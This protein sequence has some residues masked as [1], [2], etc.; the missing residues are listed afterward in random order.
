MGLLTRGSG[1]YRLH[2]GELVI[3]PK[4]VRVRGLNPAHNAQLK[5]IFKGEPLTAR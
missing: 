5:D 3:P 4:G 2:Q 1:Q